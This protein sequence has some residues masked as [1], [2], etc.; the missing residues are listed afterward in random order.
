MEM[1]LG[2]TPKGKPQQDARVHA[3]LTADLFAINTDAVRALLPLRSP[4]HVSCISRQDMGQDVESYFQ[5]V[6]ATVEQSVEEGSRGEGGALRGRLQ[7]LYGEIVG[8]MDAGKR[9]R[10]SKSCKLWAQHE[11]TLHII[12]LSLVLDVH[13]HCF[14]V[15]AL[16]CILSVKAIIK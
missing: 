3:L 7:Q 14:L 15:T 9:R 12:V 6:M 5:E 16:A 2:I 1:M 13:A 11:C 4:A 10:G 8:E